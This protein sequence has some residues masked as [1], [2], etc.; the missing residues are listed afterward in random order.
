MTELLAITDIGGEPRITLRICLPDRTVSAEIAAKSLRK[1][2][3]VIRRWARF[4]PI[5]L[6]QS[7][8]EGVDDERSE[9]A[10]A[11]DHDHADDRL[12][13]TESGHAGQIR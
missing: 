13:V 3:A 9:G 8:R 1:A 10:A 4:G 7:P 2:Q 6:S 11:K 12:S 5:F